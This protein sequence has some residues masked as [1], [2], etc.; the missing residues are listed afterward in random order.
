MLFSS[1][2]CFA[3]ATQ[4]PIVFASFRQGITMEISGFKLEIISPWF[5]NK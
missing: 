3:F 1:K 4:M 2:A 5:C